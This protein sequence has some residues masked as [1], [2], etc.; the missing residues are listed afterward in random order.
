MRDLWYGNIT[1]KSIW[2]EYE[3]EEPETCFFN[4]HNSDREYFY[5]QKNDFKN[6]KATI[7]SLVQNEDKEEY[8][9]N[10]ETQISPIYELE[11]PNF[12][13]DDSHKEE[14]LEDFCRIK[15]NTYDGHHE[16]LSI[17][18]SGE[19]LFTTPDL[20]NLPN[21]ETN[22]QNL[23]EVWNQ[24]DHNDVAIILVQP[25]EKC[26]SQLPCHYINAS[27][28]V[29]ELVSNVQSETVSEAIHKS[30]KRSSKKSKTTEFAYLLER[31]AF[32]MMRK[33]YKEKFEFNLDLADYK[34]RLPTMKKSEIDSLIFTFMEQEFQ[35][36]SGLL[37]ES[38]DY[39]RT[40]DALKTIILCD[41]YRK[42]EWISENLNFTPLRNV[43]H[44]YNTRNL[45]ELLSDAPYSFLYTHFFI[46]NGK[47]SC[48]EQSDVDSDKL[49]QRMK[50]LMSEASNYLPKEINTLF[51]DVYNILPSN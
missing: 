2:D 11:E 23:S 38:K 15:S 19:N 20:N 46:I 49:L 14:N 27:N 26:D 34:K 18:T 24:S 41:R 51:H 32:R 7:N 36:L 42:K 22:H 25:S 35:F 21:F 31:K 1:F 5:E 10:D 30:P 50:H 33:Y 37:S 44:K 9:N 28:N 40:K 39:E 45:I 13:M 16:K 3:Y 6:L 12:K 4:R 43:L 47:Q 48:E 17:Q 8:Q 29:N